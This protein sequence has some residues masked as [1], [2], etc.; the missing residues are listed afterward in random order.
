MHVLVHNQVVSLLFLFFLVK[1]VQR[2]SMIGLLS[3][4]IYNVGTDQLTNIAACLS[5]AF[6]LRLSLS[7]SEAVILLSLFDLACNS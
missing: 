7:L 3:V 4:H 2:A 6:A 5:R 1:H